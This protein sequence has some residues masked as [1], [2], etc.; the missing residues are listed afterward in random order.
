MPMGTDP[1][2]YNPHTT[3]N[4]RLCYMY[5]T[6]GHLTS[7]QISAVLLEKHNI[8]LSQGCI[9]KLLIAARKAFVLPNME[10]MRN[11]ELERLNYL[12][13]VL[14]SKVASGYVPAVREAREISDRRS[15]LMGLD[16]PVSISINQTLTIQDTVERELAELSRELGILETVS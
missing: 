11:A 15:K 4:M 3:E 13:E 16:I 1:A 6:G 10:E 9:S 2:K 7:R 5:S 12:D 14:A 8:T